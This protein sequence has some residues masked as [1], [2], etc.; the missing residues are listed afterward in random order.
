[1]PEKT[2]LRGHSSLG[3]TL[4]RSLG[5]FVQRARGAKVA[6]LHNKLFEQCEPKVLLIKE[7]Y[8]AF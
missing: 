8:K 4:V 3:D 2:V 6:I 7:P 5:V 1:M